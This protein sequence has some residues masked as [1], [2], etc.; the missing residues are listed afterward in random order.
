M[1]PEQI[2]RPNTEHAHQ[3]AYFCWLQQNRYLH[4]GFE[5]AHSIPNGGLRDK[6]TASRLK[7]EGA[8]AGAP[9]VAIPIPCGQYHGMFIEFKKPGQET[10][11]NGGLKPEQ[12][13]YRDYLI[14]QNYFHFIAYSYL[15]AIEQTLYYLSLK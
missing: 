11:K 9:D 3:A 12:L 10:L 14:S 8:R 5:F 6:I 15:T 4:A 13:K 1:T 7:A 2:A